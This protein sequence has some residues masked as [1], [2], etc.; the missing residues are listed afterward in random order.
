MKAKELAAELLKNPDCEVY[1]NSAIPQSGN[2]PIGYIY[3]NNIPSYTFENGDT[4]SYIPFWKHDEKVTINDQISLILTDK[5][6]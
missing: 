5:K 4:L 6:R 2:F 1:F 3:Q